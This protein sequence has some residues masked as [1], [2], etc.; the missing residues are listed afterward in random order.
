MGLIKS[1]SRKDVQEFAEKL[2][3]PPGS[4]VFDIHITSS[5]VSVSCRLLDDEGRWIGDAEYST[6]ISPDGD[7]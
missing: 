4:H 2:G 3:F 6:L 1:P 5:D 7:A